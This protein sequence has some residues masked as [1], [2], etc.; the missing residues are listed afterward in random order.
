MISQID[1]GNLKVV[2]KDYGKT[3]NRNSKRIFQHPHFT[4]H[5]L[6]ADIEEVTD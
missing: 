1:K 5:A 3:W 2:V 4:K 6:I